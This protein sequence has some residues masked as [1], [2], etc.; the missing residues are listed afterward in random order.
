MKI[1]CQCGQIIEV[2]DFHPKIIPLSI[3]FCEE[4]GIKIYERCCHG[5]IVLDNNTHTHKGE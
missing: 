4:C 3:G 5:Q 2:D 1:S